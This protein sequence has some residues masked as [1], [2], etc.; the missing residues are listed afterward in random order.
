MIALSVFFALRPRHID[1]GVRPPYG[2]LIGSKCAAAAD[3]GQ[4]PVEYSARGPSRP[5]RPRDPNQ[6][7]RAR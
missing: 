6:L 4:I 1:T 3:N 2:G 5:K 7:V